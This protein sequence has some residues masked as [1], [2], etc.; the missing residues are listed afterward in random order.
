MSWIKLKGA[1]CETADVTG[2]EVYADNKN[3]HQTTE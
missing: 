1:V 3:S 2:R